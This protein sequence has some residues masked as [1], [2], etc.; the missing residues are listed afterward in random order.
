MKRLTHL[1]I[2]SAFGA[3]MA[4]VAV[5]EPAQVGAAPLATEA[6]LTAVWTPSME[7]VLVSLRR[8]A[9]GSGIAVQRI[10]DRIQVTAWNDDAFAP[11][12][13]QPNPPLRAFLDE[14]ADVLA[15]PGEWRLEVAGHAMGGGQPQ[16]N[17]RLATE[18]GTA[19]QRHLRLRGFA[20]TLVT[21]AQASGK[22]SRGVELS[23]VPLLR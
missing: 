5:A 16:A 17:E 3:A 23:V 6:P 22:A 18:R 1:L 9:R 13:A 10:G 4:T 15:A 14:M 7:Q 11:N 19:V 20:A 2:G 12:S 8:T 21:A